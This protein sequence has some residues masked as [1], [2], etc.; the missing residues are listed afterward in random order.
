MPNIKPARV[1]GTTALL[2]S[3]ALSAAAQQPAQ[4][5]SSP[6]E[7][8]PMSKP[9]SPPQTAPVPSPDT[10]VMPKPSSAKSKH[11]LVGLK[12]MSSDGSN[13]GDVRAVMSTA[14]GQVTAV[15][16]KSGG[17]LGFG[18]KIVEIPDGKFARKGDTIEVS[19][20]ADEVS[21]LPEVKS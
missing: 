19:L 5:P 9:E 12:V 2:S 8:P 17:F 7:K 1:L 3:L 18:G 20:T 15:R 4:E 11:P 10:S 6:A 13:L 21:K 14:D 16:I